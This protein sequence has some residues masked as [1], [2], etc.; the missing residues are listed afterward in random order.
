MNPRAA[1]VLLAPDAGEPESRGYFSSEARDAATR[2]SLPYLATYFASAPSWTLQSRPQIGLADPELDELASFVRMRVGLAAARELEM[3][4]R[5]LEGHASFQYA[6][7]AENSVGAVRGQLDIERYL[8]TRLRPES[9]RSYPVRI[10]NRR[11]ATP[12][13]GL[14]SY[15]ALWVM[16]E[17]SLAPIHLIP[18]DAPERREILDRR[19][20]LG[21]LLRQPILAQAT[22]LA[23]DTRRRRALATLIATVDARISGGHIAAGDLYRGIVAW[24]RRFEPERTVPKPGVVE[25]AFYDDRFDTKLFELWSLAH[26]LD[27]LSRRLGGPVAGVR[28]LYE[29][30]QRAIGTWNAGAAKI[31]VYFQAGLSRLGV[32]EVRWRFTEP[33]DAALGGIPDLTVVIERLGADRILIIIDPKLRERVR[34]PTQELYKLLGYF[35]NLTRGLVPLAAIVFYSP[36]E[37]RLYRLEDDQAGRLIAVGVDPCD[38]VSAA[39]LFDR[40]GDLVLHAASISDATA[41][42][43]R[44]SAI[45]GGT[46]GEEVGAAVRQEAALRAMIDAARALPKGTLDPVRKTTAANLHDVWELLSEEASTMVVTAEYFGQNAPA[47]ADHSGPLL[48]LAAACERVLYDVLFEAAILLKPELFEGGQTLGALIRALSDATRPMPEFPEG[49]LV[50]SQIQDFGIDPSGL[51]PLVRDLR[52]LNAEYR[53]PAAHREVVPQGLWVAGRAFIITPQLGLLPRLLRTFAR[54]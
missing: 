35:G 24:T 13:N 29:R 46:D 45:L 53:I 2:R 14:A 42:M 34:A 39:T 36:A 48:G 5:K 51:R 1:E 7:V 21:R 11:Y 26:L 8:R 33:T 40:I 27:A 52:R 22:T 12:E 10:I 32:G 20:S 54:E 37:A 15:A 19:A 50:A 31:F 41:K 6:R 3:L 17:L 23:R 47:D 4:L 25:W 18:L 30:G 16:G 43:I 49:G 38:D 9:P 28:P 44:D